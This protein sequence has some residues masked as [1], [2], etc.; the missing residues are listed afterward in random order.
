VLVGCWLGA[1]WVLMLTAAPSGS[2]AVLAWKAGN[3]LHRVSRA[4]TH[5]H[6]QGLRLGLAMSP[7]ELLLTY[8]Q[9]EKTPAQKSVL[10]KKK[11]F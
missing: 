2:L 7:Q 5:Q 1:G 10:K 9:E 3:M 8:K 4:G 11:L 6:T